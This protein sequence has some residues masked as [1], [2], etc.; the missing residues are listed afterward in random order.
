M[1]PQDVGG[2]GHTVGRLFP[3]QPRGSYLRGSREIEWEVCGFAP[4][5]RSNGA[6]CRAASLFSSRDVR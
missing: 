1:P 6:V 3:S 2:K 5:R 4:H